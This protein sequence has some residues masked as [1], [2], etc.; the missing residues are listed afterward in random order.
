MIDTDGILQNIQSTL[1]MKTMHNPIKINLYYVKTASFCFLCKVQ[2]MIVTDCSYFDIYS[3]I[4][5]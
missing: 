2:Q 4:Y 3:V 1:L 5:T